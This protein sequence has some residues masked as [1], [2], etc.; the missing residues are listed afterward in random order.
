M[1]SQ[2]TGCTDPNLTNFWESNMGPAQYCVGSIDS[3]QLGPYHLF[4]P[5]GS[6]VQS[7]QSSLHFPKLTLKNT[8]LLNVC[9]HSNF[10][11]FHA[12]R[13]QLT[14]RSVKPVTLASASVIGQTSRHGFILARLES[15]EQMSYF[16]NRI[17]I[18][19]E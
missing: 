16:Q 5:D 11:N 15:R 2:R 13:N 14:E 1:R 10:L 7:H 3:L 6:P 8:L 4:N 9:Q 18:K 17:S 19:F 12:T